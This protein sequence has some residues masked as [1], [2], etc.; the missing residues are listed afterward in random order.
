MKS[1]I[2]TVMFVTTGL[3]MTNHSSAQ[4]SVSINIGNQPAWAPEGYD[5]AQYYYM[6]DMDVYYDVPAHQFVYLNNRRWVRTA[7]L[8]SAYRNYDL[9]RIH[10]VAINEREAYRHHDRDR[11]QYMQ[12][13]GKYDQ[14]PIR[15]S[16]EEKYSRNKNNWDN[17]QFKH[18]G[19]QETG[20]RDH[21]RDKGH[22]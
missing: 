13:R 8:P 15:D 2:F 11:K 14:H 16:H 18:D 1:I 12:Y 5:E 21:P 19:R 9:Y 20:M 17:N 10:K 22:H 6:P 7:V 3:L 4:V